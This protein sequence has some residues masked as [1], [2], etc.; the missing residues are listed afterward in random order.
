MGNVQQP[1]VMV[2]EDELLLH[3]SLEDALDTAG[4][5][6]AFVQSREEAA[7]LL[8]GHSAEYKGKPPRSD[9]LRRTA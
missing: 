7:L 8:R 6:V 2:V 9:A 5:S 3:E 4:F 1:L